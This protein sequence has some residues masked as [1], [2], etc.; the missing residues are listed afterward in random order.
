MPILSVRNL[1]WYKTLSGHQLIH[2][3]VIVPYPCCALYSYFHAAPTSPPLS[4][5]VTLIEENAALVSWKPPEG[6]ES[7]VTRYTILYASR[8]EWAIG[9][10]QIMHRDGNLLAAF[11]MC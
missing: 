4:V 9:Q 1:A 5:K 8:K 2:L 11:F 3:F 10:W 7:A 6:L